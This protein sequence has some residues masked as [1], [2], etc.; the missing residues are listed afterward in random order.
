METLKIGSSG[1]IVQYLQST[2]KLLG[3]YSGNI[4]GIFGNQTR[5]AVLIFQR[6]FGISQDGIV[7][8]NTWEKMST[9]FYI[10]PT[11]V[12]YGSNILS[13]N[14]DG[15][16]RKFPF[17]EQGNIGYSVLR[18]ELKYVRFGN[19]PKQIL[20]H[21]SIHANE[22]INSLVLMKFL[23]NISMAYLN[24]NTIWG[25][26]AR[27]LFQQYSLYVVPMVNPDGVD[28]VVGNTQ[29][30]N[31]NIF[32]YAKNLSKNY[33]QIVFPSG[34]KANINGV[35]LNLQFPAEWEMARQIKF[36]QGFTMPGPRDYVGSAPLVAP[37]ARNLYNFTLGKDFLLTISYHTQGQ[38]IYWK[39]LN[40]LPPNSFEIGKH[41]SQ[42]SGYTLES[43]PYA[44][45][46]AGFK[47]WFIQN[48]N[49]PGYTIETGTGQNP[50]PLTQFQEIYDANLGILV[51]GMLLV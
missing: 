5:Q 35:D 33:P 24:R 7:G 51:L 47:D 32:A 6:E 15:F 34:W 29:K 3:F 19:G 31:P 1:N 13:I 21:A 44:S 30:Y 46:F 26:S 18:N 39:F 45:G 23:E 17:L 12:S 28:L 43:T 25:Y 20:Y 22:W 48:Y 8:A 16:S 38:T 10:V 4:D 37:E 49:R 2:L 9:F 11:D 40:Y 14:L 50:L 36:S 41:F 42:V 27:S